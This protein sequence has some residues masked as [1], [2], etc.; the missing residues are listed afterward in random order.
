MKVFVTGGKGYVGTKFFEKYSNELDIIIQTHN[1]LKNEN[2]LKKVI[3][4]D[5]QNPNIIQEIIKEAPD[6]VVHLA[7][8]TSLKF[9]Q[10]E[11]EKAFDVN[12]NG[13][14]NVIKACIESK[15]KLIF[16]STKEVYG[17][18]NSKKC[19][20][21]DII[22]PINVYGLTK[23][24]SEILIKN[25]GEKMNLKYVILRVSSIY[26]PGRMTGIN[27]LFVNAVKNK[28][29]IVNDGQ[30][31]TNLIYI[32][33]FL[34]ILYQSLKNN[35]AETEIINV[36][37]K[38]CIK[39]NDIV[40]ELEKKFDDL[41]KTYGKKPEY[42]MN[43]FC[44]NIEKMNQIFGKKQFVTLDEGIKKTLEFMKKQFKIKS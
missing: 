3:Y 9:C 33:D 32:D 29:I 25:A 23:F 17:E 44:P 4:L 19:S 13:T 26:G 40:Q 27:S 10:E 20:E 14:I 41:E 1:K 11:P 31:V 42:E 35:L 12:V 36:G 5:I 37:T 7:A 21:S 15:S 39:L 43:Q 16:I 30:Q 24:V 6:I 18:H 28:K 22:K 38:E 8:K 34:D 2:S